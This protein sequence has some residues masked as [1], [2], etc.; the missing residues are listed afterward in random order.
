MTVQALASMGARGFAAGAM[1]L[2]AVAGLSLGTPAGAHDPAPGA[3]AHAAGERLGGLIQQR[4]RADG[5]FFTA[6]ERAVIERACGYAAGSWD[7]FEA[8]MSNGVFVCRDGRRVDSPEIRAVM[9]AAGPRIGARVSR[10][11]GSSQVREAMAQVTREATEAALAAIDH[12]AIA[13]E[14]AEEAR[15]AV[16]AARPEI[17]AAVREAEAAAE[18]ALRDAGAERRERRRR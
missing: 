15:R 11:M 12:A 14:A 8:N 13:R 4:L 16:E 10:V 9:A 18:R 5:P 17:E 3:E 1:A 2:A 7:G 6:E